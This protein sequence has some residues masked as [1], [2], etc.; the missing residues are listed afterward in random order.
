MNK[1]QIYDE[2][3]SPLVAQLISACQEHGIAM[4]VTFHIPT[5]D[6]PRLCC[7]SMIPNG[8]GSNPEYQ[9]RALAVIAPRR[10]PCQ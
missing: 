10:D 2:I 6:N 8:E 7:T 1:E 5:E 4:L 9:S 3:I